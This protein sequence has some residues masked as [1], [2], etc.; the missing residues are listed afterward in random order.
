MLLFQPLLALLGIVAFAAGY[1]IP[2][3]YER[4]YF[5]YAYRLDHFTGGGK[6]ATGC[7]KGDP[8]GLNEFIK[9]I[10]ED[11]KAVDITAEEFPAIEE[12]AQKIFAAKST[13]VIDTGRV[14]D[15]VNDYTKLLEKVG[16]HVEGKLYATIKITPALLEK[17]GK[18]NP[19][20]TPEEIKD[21]LEAEF[22][23][24]KS[25]I[26][27]SMTGIFNA[28]M[29]NA[30]QRF[31][32]YKGF[33]VIP[34][35]EGKAVDFKATVDK[36]PG[37]T[38]EKELEKLWNEHLEGS[39]A[40]PEDAL[41]SFQP[42]KD[43][44]VVTKNNGGSIDVDATLK[45][46]KGM[47]KKWLGRQWK[48]H[49]EGNHE[50]NIKA[51]KDSITTVKAIVCPASS[52]RVKRQ[53]LACGPLEDVLA[54]E[55]VSPPPNGNEVLEGKV[56]K[57]GEVPKV[58]GP[59][60]PKQLEAA[61]FAESVSEK[62]FGELA[63]KRGLTTLAK[64]RWSWSLKDV[65]TKLKYQPLS[66]TSPRL[67]GKGFKAP[68]VGGGALL[69]VGGT[70]YVSGI[71]EA[72]THD[73]TA[74]D[75]AAAVTAIVPFVGCGVQAASDIEKGKG[76]GL[77]TTL[78]FLGDGL[79]LTPAFPL[80]I[81]VHVVR[82]IMHAFVPPDLPTKEEMQSSRDKTWNK[83]LDDHFYTYL[84]SHT[85]LYPK[86]GFADKLNSA[87]AIEA[88]A[89]VSE[90]AQTI[91]AVHASGKDALEAGASAEEKAQIENGTLAA[92]EELR[93]AISKEIV[94]R[95]RQ[96]L[97]TLPKAL[98]D[99]TELSLK[100]T[101]E[102][103]N[104]EFTEML[105]S[106]QMISKYKKIYPQDPEVPQ[107]Q[108]LSNEEE[109]RTTLND[110]AAHLRQ[111][112]PTIPGLFDVAYIVGQSRGL[113]ALD[114]QTLSP[115][116]YVR[117]KAPE[118]SDANVRLLSLHHTRQVG[119]LL[120]GRLREDQLS[121]LFPGQDA[122]RSRDLQL[123]IAMKYGRIYDEW[124]F[125]RLAEIYGGVNGFFVDKQDPGI[126]HLVRHPDIPPVTADTLATPY[127]A[128][129]V[130][131]S[132]EIVVA[133]GDI[134]Q[135]S[136]NARLA[137]SDLQKITSVV[138]VLQQALAKYGVEDLMARARKQNRDAEATTP[139][140]PPAPANSKRMFPRSSSAYR[141]QLDARAQ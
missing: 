72:F 36:N 40:L 114:P 140:A 99:D 67:S 51:L 137:D 63:A 123:L 133:A 22:E 53:D 73:A 100:P 130:G 119:Q 111:V 65:R 139:P 124:K 41:K 86:E 71:V 141:A 20:K 115:Q 127:L 12:T 49:I 46:V 25:K 56:P 1:A 29:E 128:L 35:K 102:Q 14:F 55:E 64:E 135:G 50:G 23:N 17:K 15:G 84:Y 120:Q 45:Q 66:P 113:V 89:V 30:L 62:E 129:V 101:A 97:V 70:L 117:E 107:V 98:K 13:G 131:L 11:K 4:L 44:K 28:R 125:K 31:L 104:K 47:D 79:L 60:T 77:D 93:A 8:C 92:T 48:N 138:Q 2:G 9:F 106:K 54:A 94:R 5:Y 68:S 75:R 33:K 69:V 43:V 85:D 126:F 19:G 136:L 103:Y 39:K 10:N 80:G 134:K 37:S 87:L 112:T 38:T 122:E 81:L 6:I 132:E 57:V 16:K 18:S 61:K 82:A 95:Q 76:D 26:L 105:T 83:F 21:L 59:A 88:L 121:T 90:G 116:D 96:L 27:E 7:S 42:F 110:I 32:P 109:V 3:A 58:E 78:C 52:R 74:L 108:E 24:V 91:G 118:Q 34:D